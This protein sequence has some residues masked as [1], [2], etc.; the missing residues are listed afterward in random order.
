MKNSKN[1]GIRL[2]AARAILNKSLPDI[3]QSDGSTYTP[4][5]PFRS[6]LDNFY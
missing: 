5:E 3:K 2:G 1:D 6:A 4:G